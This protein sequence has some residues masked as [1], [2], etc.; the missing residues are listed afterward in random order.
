[1]TQGDVAEDGGT[2][3]PLSPFSRPSSGPNPLT[4]RIPRNGR[5][6]WLS[7]VLLDQPALQRE[8]KD[9][10]R[11]AWGNPITAERTLNLAREKVEIALAQGAGKKWRDW[12]VAHKR[13]AEV[14]A[15]DHGHMVERESMAEI[16]EVLQIRVLIRVAWD[17]SWRSFGTE[18]PLGKLNHIFVL[19][20]DPAGARKG[21]FEPILER[22]PSDSGGAA[23]RA[24]PTYGTLG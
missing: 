12:L 6:F 17:N 22:D 9:T 20:G 21:H 2:H 14:Q 5:C 18:D 16:A 13:P 23:G 15:L 1:M 11:D 7:L 8:W 24:P 19:G 10:S 3:P 4:L